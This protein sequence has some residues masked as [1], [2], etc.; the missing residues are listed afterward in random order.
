MLGAFF[1]WAPFSPSASGGKSASFLL[2]SNGFS[3]VLWRAKYARRGH[4]EHDGFRMLKDLNELNS[5]SSF[6]RKLN[7]R[8]GRA[9][10]PALFSL[11]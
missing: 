8:L 1:L 5:L 10:F 3:L 2:V 4:L 7:N 11:P 6:L 9:S